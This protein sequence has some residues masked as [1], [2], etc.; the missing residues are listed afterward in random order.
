MAFSIQK[1]WEIVFLHTHKL[2]PQLSLYA[3]A[4]ELHCS[5]DTVQIWINRYRKQEMFRMKK[6]E[7]EKG[8][9]QI[10]RIQRL[11]VWQKG[12]GVVQSWSS[13]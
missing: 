6:E 7:V 12:L 9:L 8:K 2:G 1:H 4:K 5:R 11:L 3:I 10:R 13:H